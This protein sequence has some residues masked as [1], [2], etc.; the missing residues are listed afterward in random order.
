MARIPADTMACMRTVPVDEAAHGH[1]PHE[2]TR[3]G[4][5]VATFVGSDDSAALCGTLGVLAD[6]WTHAEHLIVSQAGIGS[7]GLV[8]DSGPTAFLA[9]EH[10][11][12]N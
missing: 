4:D 10:P 6:Q 9:E 2:I 3:S 1:V 11:R 5:R 8:D 12:S 7:R